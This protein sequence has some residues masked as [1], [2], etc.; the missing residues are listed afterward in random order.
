MKIKDIF[1]LK[2]PN[3]DL[4]IEVEVEFK[5]RANR[6]LEDVGPWRAVGD[7]SLR[8]GV[9]YV[10]RQPLKEGPEKLGK[11]KELTG[12]LQNYAVDQSNRTSVHI[13]RNVCDF[14][15][16]EVWNALVSY[17]LI[18]ECLMHYCGEHRKGNLFCLTMKDAEGIVKYCLD[19]FKNNSPF[20]SFEQGKCKY[21][22]QALHCIATLGS[23]EYRSMEGT[24]DPDKISD[25]STAL[26]ELGERAKR[27]KDPS[28][29]IDYILDYGEDAFLAVIC[30][31]HLLKLVKKDK[32]YKEKI[33]D[34]SLNLC[35]IAYHFDDWSAWQA[36]VKKCANPPKR[37]E[38][39]RAIR[40]IINEEGIW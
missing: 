33:S 22:G 24:V 6:F 18:E 23:I 17:W 30:N 32:D 27:F 7:G 13:H 25:W 40:A 38:H 12:V 1:D 31:D 20:S 5:P 15:P 35:D 8:N 34:A 10:T 36:K 28:A 14:T 11:I 2:A 21:G 16:I 26:Y 3:G 39:Q 29:I 19:D 9:E 4:G 37:I